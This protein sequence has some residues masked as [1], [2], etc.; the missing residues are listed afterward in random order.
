MVRRFP[1]LTA[2]ALSL[3]QEALTLLE[4]AD[5]APIA[6]Y[7]RLAINAAERTDTF[8]MRDLAQPNPNQGG[9]EP[10]Q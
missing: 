5:A 2:V 10:P 9:S 8:P 1:N 6:Q 4:E 7:L 3:M